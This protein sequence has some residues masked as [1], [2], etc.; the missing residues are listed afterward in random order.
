MLYNMNNRKQTMAFKDMYTINL[1]FGGFCT[2]ILSFRQPYFVKQTIQR[3]SSGL[4]I[5]YQTII[6]ATGRIVTLSG[7]LRTFRIFESAQ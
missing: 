1:I 7:H 3:L 6:Q 5:V 4:I 2:T